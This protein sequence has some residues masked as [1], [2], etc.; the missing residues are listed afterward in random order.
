MSGKTTQIR[1]FLLA[2]VVVLA[3]GGT[4]WWSFAPSRHQPLGQRDMES[5]QPSFVADKAERVVS[6]IPT[7][8]SKKKPSNIQSHQTQGLVPEPKA[9][10]GFLAWPPARQ[11]DAVTKLQDNPH[12]D[13]P[14][15]AFFISELSDRQ[16]DEVTRNN[17]ANALLIQ[18][19]VPNSV[20]I[21]LANMIEDH[22]ESSVWRSYAVQ[23]LATAF[24]RE[25]EPYMVEALTNAMRSDCTA[26]ACTAMIQLNRLQREKVL[27]LDETYDRALMQRLRTAPVNDPM[28]AMTTLS[29]FGERGVMEALPIVREMLAN[30]DPHVRRV[31]VATL[32]RLGTTEDS[33][34]LQ[35]FL[36]DDNELVVIAARGALHRLEN[37]AHE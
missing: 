11:L 5:G 3:I 6:E 1:P 7:S 32:G 25:Q 13:Q 37:N 28:I 14:I 9:L 27:V 24:V 17:I 20:P 15:V 2:I 36:T 4:I 33:S 30:A 35:H 12:L 10:S 16:L 31:A 26:V 21:L 18:G 22:E 29:I 34:T 8:K 23:H 19:Q